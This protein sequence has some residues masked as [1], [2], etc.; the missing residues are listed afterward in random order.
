MVLQ[1]LMPVALA[2]VLIAI[3]IGVGFVI[4]G[5]FEKILRDQNQTEAA[6]NVR[7]ISDALSQLVVWIP[8]IVIIVVVVLIIGLVFGAFGRRRI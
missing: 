3:L 7:T 8:V 5:Q 6:D 2:I 1:N 4:L